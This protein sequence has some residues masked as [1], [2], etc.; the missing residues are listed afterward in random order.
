MPLRTRLFLFFGGLVASLVTA[1][2]WLVR[3]LVDDLE[4]EVGRVALDIGSGVMNFMG[5]RPT[6]EREPPR[7][8][9]FEHEVLVEDME[10][11]VFAGALIGDEAPDEGNPRGAF[12]V[13]PLRHER[14]AHESGQDDL[15][16]HHMLLRWPHPDED[17]G[18]RRIVYTSDSE[19][20]TD[21]TPR[22]GLITEER[23][24]PDA[25]V[26][27]SP[28]I[29]T[30]TTI[31]L[32]DGLDLEEIE[33]AQ[34]LERMDASSSSPESTNANLHRVLVRMHVEHKGL[35]Q[36]SKEADEGYL[37]LAMPEGDGG[38]WGWPATATDPGVAV[39]WD[40]DP[41]SEEANDALPAPRL[42]RPIAAKLAWA[43]TSPSKAGDAIGPAPKPAPPVARIPF[44]SQGMVRAIER[45]LRRL[46]L[47][48][49]GILTMGLLIAGY[50]AHRVATPLRSLSEAAQ[51]IGDGVLGVQVESKGDGEVRQTIDAFNVMSVRLAALDR[52]AA[53][54]RDREHLTELGEVAR[55][56]AHSL[57]NPLNTLGLL[58]EELASR[59]EGSEDL[60]Q[61][62]R[63]QIHRADR[64]VRTLL[65]LTGTGGA[66]STE[67]DL[68]DLARDVALELVQDASGTNIVEVDVQM[69]RPVLT[70][71]GPELRAVLHVLVV[72][73]VEASPPNTPVHVAI[74]R[75]GTDAVRLTVTDSGS[76]IPAALHAQL[77][78]PHTTTKEQGAGMGLYLARRISESRYGG[79]LTLENRP[80][81]GAVAT[82]ILS[83]R[84]ANLG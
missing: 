72:N 68:G 70:G 62:A 65:S 82:L 51:S 44:Q 42:D 11:G 46:L 66:E 57:R 67:V 81:G 60:S 24:A 12:F 69:E 49:A 75:A 31:H 5:A 36:F 6:P 58:I 38:H 41:A 56:V 15:A 20:D 74:D 19:L 63:A 64:A 18:T 37:E 34:G 39:V 54:L 84:E 26:R 4:E 13:A 55:G 9:E 17:G 25:R 3:S 43:P 78:L 27:W 45:F 8:D 77:F 21:E 83:N 35:F 16:L 14:A 7:F 22:I 79:C 1:E 48:S 50:G 10:L 76:G 59:A 23:T 33:S 40:V 28:D 47:G 2:L 71:V 30:V 32:T 73:A 29:E 61:A 80:S 53:S 52:E